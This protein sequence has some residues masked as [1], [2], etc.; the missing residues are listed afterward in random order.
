MSDEPG[1]AAFVRSM[2][3]LFDRIGA[4]P[5]AGRIFGW[6]L[7]CEPV[8]QDAAGIAAAAQASAGSISTMSRQLLQAGL[9]ERRTAP[10]SRRHLY[11]VREDAFRRMLLERVRLTSELVRLADEGLEAVGRGGE[12]AKRLEAMRSFYAFFERELP[13]LVRRYESEEA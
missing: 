7:V 2:G 10:S 5:I 8:E 13:E 1:V 3:D 11:R 12:R 4:P 9:V 6:L